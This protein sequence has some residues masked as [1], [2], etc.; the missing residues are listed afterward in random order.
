M[1]NFPTMARPL[2]RLGWSADGRRKII[3]VMKYILIL[4]FWGRKSIL[5][6]FHLTCRHCKHEQTGEASDCQKATLSE[7]AAK[8]QHD[9]DQRTSWDLNQPE[10]ELGQV[11]VCPQPGH[12]QWETI[13]DQ[14][15]HK[16]VI[17]KG[18]KRGVVK[19]YR[20]IV[21]AEND[22]ETTR[23]RTKHRTG[24]AIFSSSEACVPDRQPSDF[25]SPRPI[26]HTQ[27]D[28]DATNE[29][30]TTKEAFTFYLY[31]KNIPTLLDVL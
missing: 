19:S 1:P 14:H 8:G 25:S 24:S 29:S 20:D 15:I 2:R 18:R 23:S 3:Q 11:E 7:S 31:I 22:S 9:E 5:A 21:S 28:V 16:P 17:S 6:S 13:I 10:H 30:E 4:A 12:A 27:P 26:S